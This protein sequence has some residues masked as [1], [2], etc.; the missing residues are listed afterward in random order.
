[1][2]G[3]KNPLL[4]LLQLWL[5]LWPGFDPWPGQFHTPQVQP[6][7]E[8]DSKREV[9]CDLSITSTPPRPVSP[10][11]YSLSTLYFSFI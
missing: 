7:K 2:Q 11:A 9:F 5:Q 4:S 10:D 8:N 1:M 6:K 3:A